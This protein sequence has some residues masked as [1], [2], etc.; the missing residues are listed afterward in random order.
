MNQDD[1]EEFSLESAN[2]IVDKGLGEVLRQRPGSPGSGSGS[3]SGRDFWL[4]G[5]QWIGQDDY[6]PV[7]A[8][9]DPAQRGGVAR[10]GPR[11]P[12]RA[13]GGA[14]SGWIPAGRTA[15][16]RQYDGRG[17]FPFS[18]SIARRQGGQDLHSAPVGQI[19]PR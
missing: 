12:S 13:I 18:K 5:T 2:S 17:G 8:G 11:S 3:T 9:L 16:R 14:R 7:Y 6:D 15:P 10:L 1:Y 4:S 19:E